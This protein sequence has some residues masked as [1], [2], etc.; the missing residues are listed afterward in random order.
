MAVTLHLE[1][2]EAN[3]T[4]PPRQGHRSYAPLSSGLE[5]S[6][7]RRPSSPIPLLEEWCT[8]P[9]SEVIAAYNKATSAAA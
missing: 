1:E 4:V 5:I 6:P 8:G 9:I 2:I 3:R 7:K